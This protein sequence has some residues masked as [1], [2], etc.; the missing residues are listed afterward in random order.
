MRPAIALTT[1]IVGPAILVSALLY[2]C[3]TAKVDTSTPE[4]RRAINA[5]GSELI[6]QGREIFR[7][8]TFGSE[9]FWTKTRLHD[10]IAG[11][12]NGGVGPGVSPNMALKLGLKVDMQ[13]TPKAL[14]PLLQAGKVDLND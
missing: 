11:E 10:A 13:K 1:G 5:H 4:S 6:D 9:T 3:T 14:L 8:D 7:F 12:K 2:S